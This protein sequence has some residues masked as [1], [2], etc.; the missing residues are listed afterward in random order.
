MEGRDGSLWLATEQ[1]HIVRFRAGRFTQHPL[2]KRESRRRTRDLFVDSAGAVWVGTP[3]GLWTV[4]RDTLVRVGRGTLDA[5]VTAIVQRRD[6]SLWVGTN[7]A[8]IFRVTGDGRVTRVAADPALDADI[9]ARMVEDASGALWIAGTRALWSW[10][11]R[12]VRVEGAPPPI[13]VEDSRAGA[14][15]RGRVRRSRVRRVPDRLRHGRSASAPVR[16]ATGSG[17]GRMQR[18]SGTSTARMCSATVGAS[19]HSPSAASLSAALFDREGSLWL[20]TD[21]GGLHRLKPALFTTYSLPEGVGHPNVYAT[22]VDRSG[23]VWLGT[24]GKRREPH[25]P[26]HGSRHGARRRGR[27]RRRSI[28]STRTRRA[29]CGSQAASAYGGVYAC[30]PPAMTCRAEGPPRA[31][32][33]RG[34]RALR[35]RGRPPLGRRGRPAVSL[36]RAELDELSSVVGRARRPRCA[37]SRARA[38]ARS[39]WGRTAA[40]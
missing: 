31:P 20:G 1:G 3:D 15:D 9:I 7:G 38:T 22:Y 32:G 23:A 17:C 33:P 11:E 5:R 4:R 36:R 35:R 12:P 24:W 10:R 16:A 29:P 25:R 21:A 37:R 6:G 40:A 39:G 13:F 26:R 27:S 8:G 14:R 18:C 34:V 19:S 28:R 30:T 2:R